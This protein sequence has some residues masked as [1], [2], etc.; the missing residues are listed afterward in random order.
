M[1]T[2][3]KPYYKDRII[4]VLIVLSLLFLI[5]RTIYLQ[6]KIKRLEEQNSKLQKSILE[7]ENRVGELKKDVEFLTSQSKT[8]VEKIKTIKVKEYEQIKVI[9]TIPVSDLQK[10]FTDKYER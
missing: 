1:V 4:F 9:D 8:V 5:G 10:F 7:K 2:Y 3:L 6:T